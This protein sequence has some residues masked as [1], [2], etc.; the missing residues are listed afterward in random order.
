MIYKPHVQVWHEP[1]NR[2]S[3]QPQVADVFELVWVDTGYTFAKSWRF[4]GSG[5]TPVTY[6]FRWVALLVARMEAAQWTRE[7]RR[8]MV[9]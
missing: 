8:V 6:R 2:R 4:I 9:R 3:Y 7:W 5:N 1:D